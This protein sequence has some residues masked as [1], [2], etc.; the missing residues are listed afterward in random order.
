MPESSLPDSS[1]AFTPHALWKEVTG[2]RLRIVDWY[3]HDGRRYVVARRIDLQATPAFTE[4]QKKALAMRSAGAALKVVAFEL[5][6][7]LSTVARDV[8]SAMARLGLKSQ[9]DLAAVLG[10]AAV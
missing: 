1:Q 9:G 7:S 3:D 2:G 8:E 4:R 5:G 10:H 6:V